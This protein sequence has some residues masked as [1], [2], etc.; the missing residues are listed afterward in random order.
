MK[1]LRVRFPLAEIKLLQEAASKFN[2]VHGYLDEIVISRFKDHQVL[3]V[4]PAE[5]AMFVESY[6]GDLAPFSKERIKQDTIKALE[7]F[8]ESEPGNLP[9]KHSLR[10]LKDL[11]F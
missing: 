11:S 7:A 6:L 2:A 3:L 4:A 9:A 10:V 1:R 5:S 8:L